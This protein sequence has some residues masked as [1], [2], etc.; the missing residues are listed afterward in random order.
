MKK[1][2]QGTRV[3]ILCRPGDAA[4]LETLLLTETTTIGVRRTDVSRTVLPRKQAEIDVLGHSVR[5]KIV[6][7][8][9]GG[10][11]VKP[12][13][14]DV[15]RV[16]LATGRRAADIYQLVLGAAERL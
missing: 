14:D 6:A 8:P 13:F 11:R 2:R 5:V 3:E 10:T 15:Q 4:R 9:G 12:E 16:A 7:L 1:G